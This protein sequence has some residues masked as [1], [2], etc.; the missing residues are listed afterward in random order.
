LKE[1][2]KKT[3]KNICDL[4]EAELTAGYEASKHLVKEVQRIQMALI[5][6]GNFKCKYKQKDGKCYQALSLHHLRFCPGWKNCIPGKQKFKYERG[7][8]FK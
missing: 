2:N 1:F 5:E 8:L 6:M 7:I 4:F 3:L